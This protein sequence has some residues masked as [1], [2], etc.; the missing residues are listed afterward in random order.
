MT[1]LIHVAEGQIPRN[2]NHPSVVWTAWIDCQ[3]TDNIHALAAH[4]HFRERGGLG[5]DDEALIL[6]VFHREGR[7]VDWKK[8]RITR[9]HVWNSMP[10]TI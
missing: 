1:K 10:R 4:K 5:E 7:D 6:Y 3:P 9:D 2:F 8:F